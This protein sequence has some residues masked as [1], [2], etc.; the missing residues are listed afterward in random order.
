MLR[1]DEYVA[2]LDIAVD[3]AFT[4]CGEQCARQ[5]DTDGEHL[6]CGESV[7]LEEGLEIASRG[8]LEHGVSVSGRGDAASVNGQ[9]MRVRADPS[10]EISF[11]KQTI[12]RL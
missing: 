10:H 2:W 5:I 7:M 8:V 9:N 12:R 1:V 3:N 11:G 6:V 4:M